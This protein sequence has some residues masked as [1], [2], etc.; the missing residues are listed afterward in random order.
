M[1]T[2]IEDVKA[3]GVT[4][5]PKKVPGTNLK[6]F[7]IKNLKEVA[8]LIC[9]AVVIAVNKEGTLSYVKL[10]DDIVPAYQGAD[11][12]DNEVLDMDEEEIN[13]FRQFVFDKL[14]GI[15]GFL[16]E[17]ELRSIVDKITFHV[18]GLLINVIKL[19][20]LKK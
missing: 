4:L 16:P 11:L 9:E 18:L 15:K 5:V 17:G 19:T 20:Q 13:E 12:I 6:L 7:D 10:L 1:G 8:A 2:L 14:A 3:L